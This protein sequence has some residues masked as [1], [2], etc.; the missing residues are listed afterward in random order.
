MCVSVC[1]CVLMCILT[2]TALH[3]KEACIITAINKIVG[4]VE[5]S[6]VKLSVFALDHHVSC[7]GMFSRI[8][9]T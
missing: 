7:V 4:L 3:Y 6:K 5:E 2:A 8:R 9:K 1:I